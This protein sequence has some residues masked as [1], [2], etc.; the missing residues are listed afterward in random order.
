M[1][2]G[3]HIHVYERSY[4]MSE[5]KIGSFKNSSINNSYGIY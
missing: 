4:P 5:G 1:Y 2:F 3:A